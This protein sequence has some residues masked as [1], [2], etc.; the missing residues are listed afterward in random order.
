[1][2]QPFFAPPSVQP[3]APPAPPPSPAPS[4]PAGGKTALWISLGV[5]LAVFALVG[6]GLAWWLLGRK[7]AYDW[8][9]DARYFPDNCQMLLTVQ[10]DEFL[11]SAA[12]QAVIREVALMEYRARQSFKFVSKKINGV[13]GKG[14]NPEP[15]LKPEPEPEPRRYYADMVR[16]ET[17]L[18]L[19]HIRHL[20]VAGA[21]GGRPVVI[22][23]T[24]QA[25]SAEQI[26]SGTGHA[27]VRKVQEGTQTV[28]EGGRNSFVLPEDRT[29]VF[30]PAETLRAIVRR[31]GAATL[32]PVL[33]QAIGQAD[34]SKTVTLAADWQE[35]KKTR[36]GKGG[37][38]P[39][40]LD[41]LLLPEAGAFGFELTTQV[42]IT[43]QGIFQDAGQATEFKA[44][45]E[46]QAALARNGGGLPPG[47]T[48]LVQNLRVSGAGSQV[49]ISA[50]S[51]AQV[52]V[53]MIT[54]LG[55]SAQRT[56][57]KVAD[58]IGT[59]TAQPTFQKVPNQVS[60]NPKDK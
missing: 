18:D 55:R 16:K 29:V 14:T 42:D 57:T 5:G 12:G 46:R 28:Y 51:D 59:T 60:P 26:L 23:R 3:A 53:E 9:Q 24:S 47:L 48:K 11:N 32:S 50:S 13:D 2:S 31:N 40:W 10:V 7:Q 17:G 4:R 56:F 6:A 37:F 58:K 36:H 21:H 25:I 20:T 19:A 30:G 52:V 54:E 33:R 39:D 45:V 27:D 22:V 43:F 41:A 15:E 35:A 1:M 8:Q 34:F 44:A 38:G 49:S